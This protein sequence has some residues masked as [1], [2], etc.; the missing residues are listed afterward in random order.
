MVQAKYGKYFFRGPKPGAKAKHA[1]RI[2]QVDD[3][4]IRGSFHMTSR[5][6]RKSESGRVHHPHNHPYAE[7]LLFHGLNPKDPSYLGSEMELYVGDGFE[8][9]TI[10]KTTAVYMPP[11]MV[12]CPLVYRYKEPFLYAVAILAPLW[13]E[14]FYPEKINQDTVWERRYDK[15]FITGPKPREIRKECKSVTTYVDDDVIKGSSLFFTTFMSDG[16]SSIEDNPHTHN[17]GQ[18]LCFFGNNPEDDFDLGAEIELC[19]GDEMEK[20]TINQS[21]AVYIP[22][23]LVHGQIKYRVKKPFILMAI[24]GPKANENPPTGWFWSD[25]L[26]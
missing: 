26:A 4:V 1:I 23:G 2:A 7:I 19:M 12:H 6:F 21:T 20:H 25:R 8:R 18:L 11:G 22:P 15:Y 24:G 14:N 17:F 16:D 10:N 5:F 3:D 13:V 9:H